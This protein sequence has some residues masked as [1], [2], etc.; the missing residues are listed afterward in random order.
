M[1]KLPEVMEKM[2]FQRGVVGDGW[3]LGEYPSPNPFSVI[4]E[5]EWKSGT[6]EIDFLRLLIA[7]RWI[8]NS[9]GNFATDQ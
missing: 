9:L 5:E 3:G 6:C 4:G 7:K 2:F 1:R 8:S